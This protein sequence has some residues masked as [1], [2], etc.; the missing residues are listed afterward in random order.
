MNFKLNKATR[1]LNSTESNWLPFPPTRNEA[2]YAN[3]TLKQT[4]FNIVDISTCLLVQKTG[5]E[6][7]PEKFEIKKL[8][9]KRIIKSKTEFQI[10]LTIPRGKSQ[11]NSFKTQKNSKAIFKNLNGVLQNPEKISGI[12]RKTRNTIAKP[13]RM[14]KNLNLTRTKPPRNLERILSNHY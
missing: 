7:R 4:I 10:I 5:C 9:K 2:I 6:T 12:L 8:K 13:P 11:N 1:P 14:C 3:Y